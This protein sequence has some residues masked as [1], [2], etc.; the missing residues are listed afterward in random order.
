MTHK[1]CCGPNTEHPP[2][3]EW[4]DATQYLRDTGQLEEAQKTFAY[5]DPK[6]D[7]SNSWDGTGDFQDFLAQ[8]FGEA[9]D[10]WRLYKLSAANMVAWNCGSWGPQYV[11]SMDV[12]GNSISVPGGD[13]AI[14][15]PDGSGTMH[16]S[17]W[18]YA[19][20][21]LEITEEGGFSSHIGWY[22]AP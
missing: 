14:W 3:F 10:N 11:E 22:Y 20:D 19:A 1:T 21:W 4:D 7:T 9:T 8:F 5:Y 16:I 13:T 6:T 12:R 18:P 17:E 15:N 2:T